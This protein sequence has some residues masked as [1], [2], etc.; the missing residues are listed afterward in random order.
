MTTVDTTLGLTPDL[1]DAA[2]RE[3]VKDN[4]VMLP[5]CDNKSDLVKG[6]NNVTFS[7]WGAATARSKSVST[8]V[9]YDTP[10]DSQVTLT[11]NNHYYVGME[12]EDTAQVI[13]PANIL[14]WIQKEGAP[15][16]A[17]TIDTSM[18]GLY[19]AAGN[20]V[21]GAAHTGDTFKADILRMH[22]HLEEANC[23][24]QRALV[25]P[26]A[27]IERMLGIGASLTSLDYNREQP[28]VNGKIGHWLGFDIYV[29]N[30]CYSVA[31]SGT[32]TYYGLAF[33]KFAIA[34]AF[35]IAPRIQM[36][37][38]VDDL[39]KKA[40]ADAFWGNKS[41]EDNWLCALTIT[42]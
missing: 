20:T 13:T 10:T 31:A 4:L 9:T 29:S 15:A 8:A 26:P 33:N 3:S 11:L 24:A 28:L 17:K 36:E 32:T 16:L 22:R 40:V 7:K 25:V 2:V 5:L 42:E 14:E 35:G 41:V 34:Y 39:A 18:F 23:P 19:S 37:Y 27:I 12:V 30:N 1:L 6:S 21:A 38:S